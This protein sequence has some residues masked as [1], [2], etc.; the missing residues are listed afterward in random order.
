MDDE[1]AKYTTA[2]VVHVKQIDR[3]G[4]VVIGVMFFIILIILLMRFVKGEYR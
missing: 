3:T 1:L 4:I 2:E